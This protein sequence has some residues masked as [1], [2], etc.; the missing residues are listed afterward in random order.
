MA[1]SDD[2]ASPFH[3]SSGHQLP[4]GKRLRDPAVPF[5]NNFWPSG[6]VSCMPVLQ[7]FTSVVK[8]TTFK[9]VHNCA[10]HQCR[11][12]D[13]VIIGGD[14]KNSTVDILDGYSGLHCRHRFLHTA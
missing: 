10:R 9:A 5:R 4:A 8:V 2:S 7:I 6:G 1:S 13:F 14:Q 3:R 11:W 12:P